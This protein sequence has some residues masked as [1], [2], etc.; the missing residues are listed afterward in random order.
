VAA[1]HSEIL[2]I[3]LVSMDW[4]SF[5]SGTVLAC[6]MSAWWR[7]RQSQEWKFILYWHG[8]SP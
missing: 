3:S 2:H 5:V 7:Q 8:F 4:S 1:K 6:I